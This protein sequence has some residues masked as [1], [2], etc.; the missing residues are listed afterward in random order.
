MRIKN[1]EMM[2]ECVGAMFNMGRDGE[3]ECGLNNLMVAMYGEDWDNEDES[4]VRLKKDILD[5]YC[6]EVEVD[7]NGERVYLIEK[8]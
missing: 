3:G 5:N 6:I 4:V 8:D 7:L 1:V 2:N